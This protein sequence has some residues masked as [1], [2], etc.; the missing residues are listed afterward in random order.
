MF[1]LGLDYELRVANVDLPGEPEP[2]VPEP[3]FVIAGASPGYTFDVASDGRFLVRAQT[4]SG[5]AQSIKLILNW[6]RL[7]EQPD[8]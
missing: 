7:L 8:F 5:N 6:P 3:L 2:G 4:S 1:F